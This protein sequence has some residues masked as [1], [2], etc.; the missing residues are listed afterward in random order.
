M[1]ATSDKVTHVITDEQKI[2]CNFLVT[3][4]SQ[5][6][7]S[8]FPG[9][10]TKTILSKAIFISD[11]SIKASSKNEVTFL[12]LVPDEN[13]SLPVTVLEVGSNV[14]VSPQNI[15]VVY[16]WGLSQ[17]EDSKK[18]LLPVAKKL[19]NFT[20]ENSEKPKLLWSCYYNQVFVECNP[21][22][23]PHKNMFIVSPPSNELD[24]DF[25]ISEAKKIFSSMF[26]NEEFLPR[27][28]DPEEIILDE[29]QIETSENDRLH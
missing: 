23:L 16:C 18:D 1:D 12:R 7:R 21:D 3:A 15:F 24:Y 17:S 5:T 9:N 25:A 10:L 26:P 20:N 2:K 8:L 22:C 4:L 11:G 19:F 28:P 14:H 13:I 6:P 29:P 27:A